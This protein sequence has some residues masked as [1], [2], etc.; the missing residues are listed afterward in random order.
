MR[1]SWA[2]CRAESRLP[3]FCTELQAALALRQGGERDKEESGSHGQLWLT[4][5]KHLCLWHTA[6]RVWDTF[7]HYPIRIVLLNL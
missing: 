6:D 5:K 2:S 3:P 4:L 1:V 7:D